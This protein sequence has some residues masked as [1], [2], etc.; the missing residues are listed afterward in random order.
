MIQNF[1]T[2][3]MIST[4]TTQ[5]RA[6]QNVNKTTIKWNIPS[7]QCAIILMFHRI[8]TALMTFDQKDI[9]YIYP[10]VWTSDL[11]YQQGTTTQQRETM[12][13]KSCFLHYFFNRNS[14]LRPLTFDPW[15]WREL[16]QQV[17]KF[18]YPPPLPRVMIHVVSFDLKNQLKS[19]IDLGRNV[20]CYHAVLWFS[21]DFVRKVYVTLFLSL[22]H[23]L[24]HTD[25]AA[26]TLLYSLRKSLLQ[27]H[28]FNIY[29]LWYF[30]H[31]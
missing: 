27:V 12:R 7:W 20:W 9:K 17:C 29:L 10:V 28:V 14:I 21:L 15:I 5:F 6:L 18:G 23:F 30:Q 3:S 22:P 16:G 24:S 31:E 25:L 11:G 26:L 13:D 2:P 1:T 8:N 4:S 19:T